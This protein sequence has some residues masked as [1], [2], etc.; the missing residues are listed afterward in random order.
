MKQAAKPVG[1]K[2]DETKQSILMEELGKLQKSRE[3]IRDQNMKY[4]ERHPEFKTLMDEFATAVIAEKPS[5]IIKFCLLYTSP[6]PRDGL[7][8]RMPSSA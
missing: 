5:D 3:Q 6:S 2:K 4:V 1:T 7:V 8:S